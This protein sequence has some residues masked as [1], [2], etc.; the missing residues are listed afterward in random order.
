M[1][2][3]GS[4][5]ARDSRSPFFSFTSAAPFYFLCFF[6]YFFSY[7]ASLPSFTPYIYFGVIDFN[8]D[9]V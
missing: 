5:P 7:F 8:E 1:S 3:S 2:T 9:F 6:L 4:N